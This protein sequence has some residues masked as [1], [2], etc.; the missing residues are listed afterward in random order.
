MSAKL[1]LVYEKKNE[2]Y[3]EKLKGIRRIAASGLT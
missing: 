1:D 3:I 2:N